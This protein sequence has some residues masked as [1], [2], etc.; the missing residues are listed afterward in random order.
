MRN[1][2][3][4]T[5]DGRLA[6]EVEIAYTKEGKAYANV[7]LAVQ[8]DQKT[9]WVRV[10]FWDKL[11]EALGKYAGK[12]SL[13]GVSG[14]LSVRTWEKDGKKQSIME[15]VAND[16]FLLDKKAD[17]SGGSK[18]QHDEQKRNGYQKQ[19]DDDSEIPF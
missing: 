12:G 18:S 10:T 1:R 9:D 3:F 8:Y 15:V 7:S 6:R 16:L 14:R 2:N 17:G 11:A 5:L 4:V 19:R 13:I